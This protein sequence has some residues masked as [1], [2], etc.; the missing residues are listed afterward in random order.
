MNQNLT[1][2]YIYIFIHL[3]LNV[4]SQT[5]SYDLTKHGECVS[6]NTYVIFDPT[7]FSFGD[8]MFFKITAQSFEADILYYEYLD[9]FTGYQF[10]STGS[11]YS[12]KSYYENEVG[13]GDD[14][15]CK[16]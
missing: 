16:L 12:V 15:V 1:A 5:I 13:G 8:V 14:D 11:C 2:L 4:L 7:G 10:V 6:R 3:I 9:D